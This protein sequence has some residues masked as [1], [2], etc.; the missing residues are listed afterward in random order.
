ME[1]LI[2]ERIKSGKVK[3]IFCEPLAEFHSNLKFCPNREECEYLANFLE[4]DPFKAE[5]L[6]YDMHCWFCK[7]E[8][9]II[10]ATA[11]GVL[12]TLTVEPDFGKKVRDLLKGAE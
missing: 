6:I 10:V 7:S 8:D 3:V 9:W 2:L 12:L 5:D 11:D 1:K 4:S